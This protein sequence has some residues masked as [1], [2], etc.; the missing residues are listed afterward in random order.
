M[1]LCYRCCELRKIRDALFLG[2]YNLNLIEL[3][4]TEEV[5]FQFAIVYYCGSANN[6]NKN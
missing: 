4:A 3:D 6:N 2:V 5:Q 1:W